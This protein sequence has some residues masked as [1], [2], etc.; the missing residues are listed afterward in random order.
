MPR[1]M[2]RPPAH[3]QVLNRS[4][5]QVYGSDC[6]VVSKEEAVATITPP[7]LKDSSAAQTCEP[8]CLP[9]CGPAPAN[10][11]RRGQSAGLGS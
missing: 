8:L 7:W 5:K 6:P 1:P 11:L 4:P 2:P 9:A 10:A 3:L